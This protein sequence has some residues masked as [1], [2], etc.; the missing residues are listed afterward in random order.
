VVYAS[1]ETGWSVVRM[2]VEGKRT[3]VTA[4]G[5]LHGAQPGES[6]RLTGSWVRDAKYGRQFRVE[7]FLALQPTTADGIRRFLGS[8]LIAGIGPAMA[9]RIVDRFGLDT[10][11]VIESE[12]QRL[13]EVDGIGPVRSRRISQAYREQRDL[14][15]ALVFLQGYG[16]SSRLAVRICQRYGD[17]TVAVLRA[18]PYRLAEEMFGVGFKTADRIASSIG[19]GETS[20]ERV[21]A[22]LLHSLANASDDGHLFLP[23]RRLLR[24][25]AELLGLEPEVCERALEQLIDERQ[26][27]TEPAE[28]DGERPVYLPE[29]HRAEVGVAD[30][31][32]RLLNDDAPVPAIKVDKAIDWFERRQGFELAEL[33]REAIRRGLTER[34][35]VI[36]GGPGT[37]KTTLVRAIT[38]I[39]GRKD[40]R[41]L[42]AAPTGRAAKRL[43][44]ATGLEARTI[45]RLLEFDPHQHG[46]LRG[47]GRPL[48][49]DVVI[50]D[51]VSMLDCTLTH[52]L[53]RALPRHCRLIL[54][55]DADQLPS[56]GPG[57]VLHDLI[58]SR[59][60]P[61][62]PLTEIFRQARASR[63]VRNAH[64]VNRGQMP[65][66]ETDDG[67]SDFFFIER[68][69]PAEIL[70]TVRHL[71]TDRIPSGFG[72]DP[73]RDIQVLTPMRRGLLGTISLNQELQALLNPES[74]AV[75]RGASALRLGD[76]VMQIRNNYD[77]GVFNGDVGRIG[78]VDADEETVTVVFGGRRVEYEPAQLDELLLA[79]A[80]SVHKSQGSEYPCV[81]LPLH[82]QHHVMLQR[83]LLYTALT[84]AQRLAIVVGTRQ[85]VSTAVRNHRPQ[86]R[87]TRLAA[88]LSER[89]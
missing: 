75:R 66:L 24:E 53:L 64:L 37:G 14:R 49:G 38:E 13:V 81:V 26:L 52:L 51:E 44:E 85:A 22:G 56:V 45:H 4:V 72:L 82:S 2:L 5:N 69:E 62:V 21:R 16:I 30:T 71:V 29:L 15:D 25:S 1:D 50:V 33:Q 40:Q 34:I 19:F 79:Y 86:R 87:F 76:R 31:L 70:D 32:A 42:L 7:S 67:R 10:L 28:A 74:A 48:E 80:C 9:R 68:R 59:R 36:T 88:R 23:Q 54:I 35:L 27:L 73:M 78:R 60:I 3:E 57:R 89:L 6:L 46:F 39:L 83:N 58:A 47:P 8:G 77:L 63:I 17:S 20:P 43:G 12:P 11:Q 41:L 55:G 65:E 84:R 61:V 18:N